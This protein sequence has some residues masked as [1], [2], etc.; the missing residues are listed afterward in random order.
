MAISDTVKGLLALRGKKQLDL[1][2]HFEM[3]RQSMS[4]KMARNSWSSSDLAKVAKFCGCRLAF[5]LPDG[6]H[7]YIDPDDTPIE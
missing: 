7:I 3:S 6:E 1:A 4:N 2:A 5:V